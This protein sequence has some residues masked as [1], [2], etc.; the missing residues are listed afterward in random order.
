MVIFCTYYVF[1]LS[2]FI[3]IYSFFLHC[4][5]S[6]F[7]H[8]GIKVLLYCFISQ[9]DYKVNLYQCGQRSQ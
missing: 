3:L 5:H 6:R 2:F 7:L 4:Y 9:F 1:F 8:E